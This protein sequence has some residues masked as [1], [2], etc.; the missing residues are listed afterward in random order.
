MPYIKEV[1]HVK[2]IKSFV[3]SCLALNDLLRG[4]PL[5]DIIDKLPDIW[6]ILFRVQD[7]I[8]VMELIIVQESST[9]STVIKL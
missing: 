8:K 5:D 9:A 1:Q 3:C 7:D 2:E 6:E 4:R